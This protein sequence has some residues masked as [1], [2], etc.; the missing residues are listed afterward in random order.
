M[1]IH[2]IG[3]CFAAVELE[4]LVA[5]PVA[6]VVVPVALAGSAEPLLVVEHFEVAAQLA[7]LAVA[8]AATAAGLRLPEPAVLLAAPAVLAEQLA[9]SVGS[10]F[11]VPLRITSS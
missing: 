11:V 1:S 2:I 8:L 10:G 5:S 9:A 7:E 3:C 6:A 4:L